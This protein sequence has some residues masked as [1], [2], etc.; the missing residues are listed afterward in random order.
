MGCL[1]YGYK[2]HISSDVRYNFVRCC[3]VTDAETGVT[4]RDRCEQYILMMS[5]MA[6]P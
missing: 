6:I 5:T 1:N 3:T 2:N 4:G